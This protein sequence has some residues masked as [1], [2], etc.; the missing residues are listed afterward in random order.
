MS[1]DAV[2]LPHD[3]AVRDVVGSDLADTLFVEAGAGSGKTT[4]LVNRVCALV[5]SGVDV[6]NVAAITFTE[7]AASELRVRVRRKLLAQPP[8]RAV[9]VALD[10]LGDAPMSTLHAFARRLLTEHGVAVG[11]PPHFE[12]LDTVAEAIYLEDRWRELAVDLFEESGPLAQVVTRAAELGLKASGVRE[13]VLTLHQSYDRLR[14]RGWEWPADA[15]TLPPIDLKRVIDAIRAAPL[16]DQP[17]VA[18]YLERAIAAVSEGERIDILRVEGVLPRIAGKK[19]E[20]ARV[21]IA[22]SADLRRQALEALLPALASRVLRWAHERAAEGRLLFHDLLVLARDALRIG[23]VRAASRARYQRILID[24]FQ[25]TDPLQIEIAVLLASSRG[26]IAERD[27]FDNP[28]A[29]ADAGRLFFVGD[30]KQSIYRFR[31]ADIDLYEKAQA[32]FADRPLHLT[33]NFRSVA[34]IVRFVN[35]L[36]EPWMESSDA[37]GQPAYTSLTPYIDDHDTSPTVGF[38]GDEA[39]DS[40]AAEI[41]LQEADAVVR[42]IAQAKRDGWMVRDEKTDELRPADYRDIAVLM[43]T[44]ASLPALDQGLDAAGIP[45]RVESR[46]LIWN[47]PEVRDLLAVLSAVADSNDQVAI[48]AAL[49]SAGLGCSDRDLATWRWDG[50]SWRYRDI[51]YAPAEAIEHPV[52]QALSVL[53]DLH[54]DRHGL[55]IGEMVRRVVDVC[56]LRELAFAHARPRDRWRRIDFFLAQARA[57]EE[58]GGSS[59]EEF[60]SW[61]REQADRDVWE[62]DS[63][64]PDPDDDAVRVLTVHAS[65]GLEFPIVVLMGLNTQP[66]A[67]GP[68]ILWTDGGIEA[69]AGPQNGDRFETAGY[70]DAWAHEGELLKS[71]RVRLAY[72]AMTRAHDRLV[73]S[74]F[75]ATSVKSLAREMTPFLPEAPI[76]EPLPLPDVV[77]PPV[78][79]FHHELWSEREGWIDRRNQAVARALRPDAVPATRVATLVSRS[80]VE[81]EVAADDD[82]PGDDRPSSTE[83]DDRGED[84]PPWRRGRA[85]TAIG[86]AVHA[87]LQ[88]IDLATGDGAASLAA[89][90]AAAEGVPALARDIERRVRSVLD[91]PSV[92]EALASGRYWREVFVAVPIGDRV[93]EGFID[94]LY[95]APSGELVVVDYKTDGVRGDSDA[96]EAVGRYRLQAAA[97]TLAVSRSL[98]RPVE[99]CVFVFANPT[100]WFER[101][102]T[103]V[104]AAC[105]EV[106]ALLTSG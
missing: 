97:Y 23:E 32:V 63:V 71:E 19:G 99:R 53:S 84:E 59:I 60:V 78:E 30:P 61:A 24:E 15:V 65:K 43:P 48:V 50:R 92:H 49:R 57:F 85:G 46:I 42:A 3:Q 9:E 70:S 35:S 25:D 44:R 37:I 91:A 103:D 16:D 102:L 52:G 12:V 10:A 40:P 14:G 98:R 76:I 74:R 73:V 72:V 34:S 93:L 77:M 64:E 39:T 13:I 95:E 96:D 26:D 86:R 67:A 68:P 45:V 81:D 90:Q 8:S 28:L 41:R 33:E 82:E 56:H 47:T 88:T 54:R 6:R 105:D 62:N 58:A 83:A 1:D 101:E 21:V 104:A 5:E 79:R 31:R 100:R 89:A 80:I 17:E 36:F 66:R 29:A 87:V 22:V 51:R 94:L 2:R 4:I 11:V 75:R 20:P 69:K 106:E 18:E 55:S 38:V 7:K 27:W